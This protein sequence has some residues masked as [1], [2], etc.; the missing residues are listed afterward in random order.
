MVLFIYLKKKFAI[1]FLVFNNKQYPNKP[2]IR[3]GK[4]NSDGINYTVTIVNMYFCIIIQSVIWVD[5]GICTL[6]PSIGMLKG[7]TQ[8]Q[9]LG[10]PIKGKHIY[11][12]I[13]FFKYEC[14]TTLQ[15]MRAMEYTILVA[16]LRYNTSL[17]MQK[18]LW[19]NILCFINNNFKAKCDTFFLR[20]LGATGLG[21]N[22]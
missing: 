16:K 12:E 5:F 14:M 17:L 21:R 11:F 3:K 7:K 15:K 6:P 20:I 13:I 18:K 9:F 4:I 10:S 2:R 1:V 19:L 22:R 8:L